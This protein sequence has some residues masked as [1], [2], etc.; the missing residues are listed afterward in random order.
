MAAVAPAAPIDIRQRVAAQGG[1]LR[2]VKLLDRVAV[3]FITLGGLFV[4][5]AVFFI[6]LFIVRET[7]PLARPASGRAAGSVL[8]TARPEAGRPLVMGIDEY[9]MYF[10]EVLS[11]GRIAFWRTDGSFAKEVLPEF[12]DASRVAAAS[13]SLTDNFVAIGTDDGRVALRQVRFLPRYADQ[14]LVDLDVDVRDRGLVELDAT[15]RP[16]REVA[17]EEK[18]GRKTV[19]GVPGDD[20][21]LFYRTD[22]EGNEQRGILKTRDGER[23]TRVRIARSDTLIVA[24]EKGSLH[25]WEL[26]P[27]VRLTEVVRVSEDPVTAVEMSLGGI[28]ALVGDARGNLS[29]WFRVRLRDDDAELRFVRAHVYPSQG[30]PIAAIGASTRDKS[31]VTAGADGSLVLRHMT[32]ERT[33][34]S[35]PATGTAVENVMLTP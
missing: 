1:R 11:D 17:Y 7:L 33:L 5:I 31:F 3:G 23:V 12:L 30:T 18:D 28:T 6:F 25:H 14:K 15:R 8:L 35:F 21:I 16:I 9:Q 4:I 27:E 2:R 20:E 34:V 10:Y 24:T 22:D 13:K 29:A 26:V 19:V 32:S